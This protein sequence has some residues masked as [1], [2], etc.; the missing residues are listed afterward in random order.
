MPAEVT[1]G[2]P[3]LSINRG[4]TFMV[5]DQRGEIAPQHEQGIFA[6]DTRF[7]SHYRLYIEAQ[8]W[9]LLTSAAVHHYTVQVHLANPPVTTSDGEIRD[10]PLT[11]ADEVA[12]ERREIRFGS[13]PV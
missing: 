10:H 13:V 12:V 1:V 7:V 4:A 11:G 6:A 9:D 8:P 5:T 2:P 3:V